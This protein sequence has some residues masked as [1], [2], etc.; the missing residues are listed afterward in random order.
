MNQP[1][2]LHHQMKQEKGKACLKLFDIDDRNLTYLKNTGI[3]L[4]NY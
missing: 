3:S 1:N 2:E 4:L